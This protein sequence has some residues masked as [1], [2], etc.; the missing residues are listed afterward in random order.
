MIYLSRKLKLRN[1]KVEVKKPLPVVKSKPIPKPIPTP[2]PKPI[3]PKV[4]VVKPI[5]PKTT[6]KPVKQNKPEAVPTI[7]PTPK[8]VLPSPVSSPKK[9]TPLTSDSNKSDTIKSN[10]QAQADPQPSSN[11]KENPPVKTATVQT[12]PLPKLS[13]GAASL[14]GVQGK[15]LKNNYGDFFSAQALTKAK[16][17]LNNQPLTISQ[18]NDLKPYLSGLLTIIDRNWKKRSDRYS[19][20]YKASIYFAIQKDGT[21]S[22]IRVVRTNGEQNQTNWSSQAIKDVGVYKPL[23]ASYPYL[24]HEVELDFCLYDFKAYC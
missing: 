6:I 16:S 2:S 24:K 14:M 22:N 13:K 12:T 9:V 5:Q 4:A 23:P 17:S 3:T 15:S 8:K 18:S 1:P 11:K 19:D 10:S 7:K 20:P 21:L